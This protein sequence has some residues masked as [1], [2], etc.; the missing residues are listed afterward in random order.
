MHQAC[1]PY[2]GG[3]KG[4][5]TCRRVKGGG[6]ADAG[7]RRIKTCHFCPPIFVKCR[8]KRLRRG[9]F[10]NF[11]P[12]NGLHISCAI[13]PLAAFSEEFPLLLPEERMSQWIQPQPE[14]L[15]TNICVM[16][17]TRIKPSGCPPMFLFLFLA[18]SHAEVNAGGSGVHKLTLRPQS[19]TPT[20]ATTVLP[21]VARVKGLLVLLGCRLFVVEL[22]PAKQ[23]CKWL[24]GAWDALVRVG[25]ARELPSGSLLLLVW[26]RGSKTKEKSCALPE[27]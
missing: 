11:T 16:R 17:H 27:K 10:G 22:F 2:V 15:H 25:V 26:V 6:V 3:E 4:C 14:S 20:N 21:R 18:S 12:K 13:R 24:A 8:P 1:Y 9:A 5:D 23:T 19:H 7:R